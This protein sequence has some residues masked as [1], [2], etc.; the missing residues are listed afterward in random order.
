FT[1]NDKL[2]EPI[3]SW[4]QELKNSFLAEVEETE[5]NDSNIPHLNVQVKTVKVKEDVYSLLFS[6]N[7]YTG[8]ANGI[9]FVKP[10]TVDL[11]N[12]KIL[13]LDSIFPSSRAEDMANLIKQEIN[14]HPKLAE[15]IDME[16]LD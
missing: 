11:K 12:E 4:I 5:V 2:N 8:G 10:F 13:T 7:Q 6:A 15:D 1:K 3:E 9:E 16:L 14:N